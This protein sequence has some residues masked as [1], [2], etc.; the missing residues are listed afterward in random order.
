MLVRFDARVQEGHD[1]V[2]VLLCK[3][4]RESGQTVVSLVIQDAR[5]LEKPV[6][7]FKILFFARH[8]QGR[9]R[10]WTVGRP[11][12]ASIPV[13]LYRGCRQLFTQ[14]IPSSQI[15]TQ[16]PR[17]PILTAD[18]IAEETVA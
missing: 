5:D 3:G 1:D 18:A 16:A 13:E 2:M 15:I 14:T 7:Q 12:A 4:Y 6:N 17:P 8:C 10:I 11:A 9:V